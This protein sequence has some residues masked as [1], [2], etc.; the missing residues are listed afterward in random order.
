M[1]PP[2]RRPTDGNALRLPLNRARA[3]IVWENVWPAV[4][5]PLGIAALFVAAAWFDWFRLFGGWVHLA[6]LF[7][8]AVTFAFGL[9]RAVR[10]LVWPDE[11]A[12]WRRLERDN[13]LDHRPISTARDQ[14]ASSQDPV[15]AA[16]WKLHQQSALARLRSIRVKPP[17][18]GLALRDP[19]ALRAA[20]LVILLAAG[21]VAWG[22][23]GRR[24]ALAF[25]PRVTSVA[26]AVPTKLD[27]W[28]N[29]PEYTGLAPIFLRQTPEASGQGAPIGVPVNSV[30][31]ARMSGRGTVPR[32]HANG[33]TTDFARV[34]DVSFQASQPVT[35]G[36]RIGVSQLTGTI[37]EW[38]ITVIPDKAPSVAFS[39]PPETTQ[40]ATL[41]LDYVAEDDYGVVKVDGSIRL[42]AGS[43]A[44][45][46]PIE[47][48][49]PV[50][51][52][53]PKKAEG[54]G[55]QDLT[56]HPWA[57]LPVTMRL[58][59][60]DGAGQTGQ[61]DEL[62]FVLPERQFKHPVAR[63]I[64]AERKKLTANP[65]ERRPV[66]DALLMLAA[67]PQ[68]YND[69]TT[70]FLA[71]RSAVGR[72]VRDTSAQ[73]V[74]S[75]QQLLW[76]TALRVEDGGL[77]I[78][79]RDLRAAQ[80]ALMDALNRP[81][82]TD[83]ELK[84][85]MDQLQAAM[86][87]L[88]DE[89]Q[90][91][92]ER[93]LAQGE[94]LEEMQ[95]GSESNTLTRQDLQQMMDR[96]REMTQS[97]ARDAARQMLSQLQQMMENLQAGRMQQ[98]R[99]NDQASQAMRDLQKLAELQQRLM[100]QT[101]KEA[102][103][104]DGGRQAQQQQ[105]Q[106]NNQRSQ[107]SQRGQQGQQGHQ[108][109][110]GQQGQGQQAQAGQGAAEQEALRRALGELM[111]RLGEMGA[112]IP[113]PLGRAEQAMRGAGQALGQNQPGEAVPHQGDALDALQQGMQ[114]LAEQMGEQGQGQGQ[115]GGGEGDRH[116]RQTGQRTTDRN[117]DPLGRP[118]SS[119]GWYDNSE[120]RIPGEGEMRRVREILDELR[121]RSGE[122]YRPKPE[123]DYIDRL[124]RQ[125]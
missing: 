50:P 8:F 76:D 87:R 48:S 116:G 117:R 61:S 54:I 39:R 95:Q 60:S 1:N 26:T 122:S 70:V 83:E 120:V 47:V 13:A 71:L 77:S 16:L 57:G 68:L 89:M 40:R 44:A 102:Q 31:M 88:L 19:R 29:P 37:A 75:V 82:T 69:D 20:V 28:V 30:V 65:S 104:R 11:S 3:A 80:Q 118:Q 64:I 27:I 73:A 63:A 101:F 6:L 22:D 91:D 7:L 17:R 93:R 46:E 2:G 119:R 103:R 108:G 90:R 14:I 10:N 111:R 114:A 53:R 24:I 79:E 97:G 78:A 36:D 43:K 51:G 25:V 38:P 42:A 107:Q 33:E 59:A 35:K 72:L 9:I 124:L 21:I 62:S 92:V 105:G 96:M 41:R 67:R 94:R 110:Q 4:W 49:L 86:D 81:D 112:D 5:P 121:R 52:L 106:R 32:L 125:F 99:G 123:L 109:Q 74:P 18:P 56:P 113:V 84:R 45:G 55:F 12:L 23:W 98:Q 15:A 66:A 85:L 100:D 34:D 58:T 115:M